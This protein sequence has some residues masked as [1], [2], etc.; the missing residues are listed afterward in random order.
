MTFYDMNRTLFR[1]LLPVAGILALVS[2]CGGND[3]APTVTDTLT[4]SPQT[5]SF[6]AED[7]SCK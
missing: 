7:S 6:D 3:P 5:L 4:V 1:L 2:S